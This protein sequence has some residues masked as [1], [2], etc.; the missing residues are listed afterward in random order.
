MSARGALTRSRLAAHLWLERRKLGGGLLL[1]GARAGVLVLAPWPLKFMIDNVIFRD[2]LGGSMA[3][4]LPDPFHHRLQLLAVLGT[5]MLLIAVLDALL[6]Y[7]GNRLFFGAAQRA[8]FGLQRDFFAHLQ[9]LSLDFHRRHLTGELASRLID[10]VKALQDFIVSVGVDLLPQLLT[11]VGIVTVLLAIDWHYGVL[12]LAA[13]VLLAIVARCFGDRIRLLMREVR[14]GEGLQSGS[15]QETLGNVQLVQSFA[16]E[17][18]ED[19]RFEHRGRGV[20]MAGDDANR[21]QAAFSPTLNLILGVATG[22]TAWFGALLVIQGALTAGDLVVFLSYLRA[23]VTPARQVAKSGRLFGRASVALERIDD[24]LAERSAVPEPP[25]V[26]APALCTGYVQLRDVSFGYHPLIPVVRNISFELRRGRT[27][28]LV[29]AS[30]SGK[31]TIAALIARFYDPTAGQILLDGVD[32]K[33]LR[34]Q[35]VRTRVV[36]IPQEPQLF[37]APVWFNIAYGREGATRAEAIAAA[38]DAGVDD[39]IGRMPGG[40]DMMVGE[41]GLKLSGGQRQCVAIARAMLG[42]AAVIL[43]DEPSSG[44]DALT[45][46]RLM[47]ALRRLGE[48]RATLLIAHRLSITASADLILLL[49]RGRIVQRGTHAELL[50]QN[51]AYGELWRACH[52]GSAE[53]PAHALRLSC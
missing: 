16:R 37:E 20:L 42:E 7:S 38:M 44:L 15:T 14:S 13:C 48:R 39:V 25:D 31:S 12:T 24:Y 26:V 46:Q 27:V 33:D 23:I 52:A 49:S 5:A 36:L 8:A 3:A 19:R 40:Y 1:E 10:D 17:A 28:A 47:Q 45:E 43:L 18:F 21:I 29:G 11:I 41:R 4:L 50:A 51:G 6:G 34:L 9:R 53:H 32:V 30:G 35:W 2:P 22:L